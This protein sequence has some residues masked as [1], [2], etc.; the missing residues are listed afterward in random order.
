MNLLTHKISEDVSKIEGWLFDEESQLLARKMIDLYNTFGPIN[1]RVV[2][3]G[4][5]C[6]KSTIAMALMLKEIS[7]DPKLYAI[8]PHEGDIGEAEKKPPTLGKF[9]RNIVSYGCEDIIIPIVLT[10]RQYASMNS[11]DYSKVYHKFHFLFID[12]LHDPE[13]VSSDFVFHANRVKDKGFVAFHDYGTF[14]GVTEF[15]DELI[16]E[17]ALYKVVDRAKSLIVFQKVM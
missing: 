7:P 8:D 16:R 4:S 13:S 3:I 12:G 10:S 14:P 17:S 9:L 2:E 1:F 15:V 5:Y 6:G 11:M